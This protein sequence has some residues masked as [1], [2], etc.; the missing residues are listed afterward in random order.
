MDVAVDLADA[1]QVAAMVERCVTAYGR[2]DALVNVAGIFRAAPILELSLEDYDAVQAVNTR[3]VFVATQAAG[4]HMAA[5]RSGAVVTIAS[6]AALLPRVQ[7]GAYCTSKAAVAHLTRCFGLELAQY[8][9]RC[10]SVL[11]GAADTPMVQQ[12]RATLR[13]GD[14][15]ETVAGSIEKF[16]TGIPLGRLA[17]VE[18]IANAV[19]YLLSDQAAHI[20]LHDLVVDGGGSLGV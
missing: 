6:N 1:A 13:P 15:D 12:L 10:N 11:P 14:V 7:Q 20:T 8:G 3:A 19:L 5:A 2:V 17:A 9:I 4:R 16:R 18:Q